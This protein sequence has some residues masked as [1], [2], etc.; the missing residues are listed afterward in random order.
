MTHKL[1]LAP[2][3]YPSYTLQSDV[4]DIAFMM[5]TLPVCPSNNHTELKGSLCIFDMV[6]YII[7][8][9]PSNEIRFILEIHCID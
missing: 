3:M 4:T 7:R 2:T 1:G 9:G 5:D 8:H 6:S